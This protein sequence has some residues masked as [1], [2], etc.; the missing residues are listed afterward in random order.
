[1][2]SAS[3][4][5]SA[6]ALILL[7]VTAYVIVGGTI[8]A[9]EVVTIAQNDN[10]RNQETRMRTAIEIVD[11]SLT[12][13]SSPLYIN[14]ENTGSEPVTDFDNMAVF[15][16]FNSGSVY[17]PRG[18]GQG[19]WQPAGITPDDIHPGQLD[20]DE[21]M[22]ISVSFDQESRP[23]WVKIVTGNGVYDSG[24]IP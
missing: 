13:D 16:D 3:L 20:P 2:G 17:F 22:N 7:L 8:A 4:I 21:I 9:A 15:L 18:T 19:A 11:I 23:L 24:Y 6:I 10:F 12:N 5:A 14:V 1:M